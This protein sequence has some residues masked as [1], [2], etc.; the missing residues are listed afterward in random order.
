LLD[1]FGETGFH[2]K[3]FDEVLAGTFQTLDN[4]NLCAK[5]TAVAIANTSRSAA[6]TCTIEK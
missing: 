5:K 6:S 4:F 3:A 2:S 1:I